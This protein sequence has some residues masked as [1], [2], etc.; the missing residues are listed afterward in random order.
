[1]RDDAPPAA[2]AGGPQL[3]QVVD[4][5]GQ[6]VPCEEIEGMQDGLDHGQTPVSAHK[7]GRV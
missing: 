6:T 3:M 2:S 4:T 5:L 7:L 1:M